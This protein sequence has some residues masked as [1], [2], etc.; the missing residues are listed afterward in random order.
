M[1]SMHYCVLGYYV[2]VPLSDV[3]QEVA[4]H[5]K[6]LASL[7]GTG[8]IYLSKEGINA[9]LA[10]PKDQV[11]TYLDWLAKDPRFAKASV[12]KHTWHESPFAKLTVKARQELVATGQRAQPSKGSYLTPHQWKNQLKAKDPHTVLIDVRN[13]YESKIGHFK[14]AILPP[15]K[16]FREFFPYA[17]ELS[18]QFDT[19]KTTLMIYCTGGIRCELYASCLKNEGFSSLCQLKGGVIQYGL[20]EGK[21]LWEGKL[22]VFDDRLVV[23]IADGKHSVISSCHFCK[24]KRDTYYNCA[25]MDCNQLFVACPSCIQNHKGCCSLDCLKKGNV[26]EFI[27]S[28]HPK[29]FRKLHPKSG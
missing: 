3:D 5:K 25:N 18:Q 24:E 23:P 26:R 15:L 8:R 29:P 2:F 28:Q 19:K 7:N 11:K 12:N 9:Q 27:F 22:F 13:E 21:E 20:Q 10:L 16:T 17:K 14:G 6:F 1:L 4:H